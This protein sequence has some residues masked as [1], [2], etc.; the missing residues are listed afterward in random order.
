MTP[1]TIPLPATGH[2]SQPGT[3]H[4]PHCGKRIG[5]D[6]RCPHVDVLLTPAENGG[7]WGLVVWD[8]P[9]EVPDVTRV[10][11]RELSHDQC[12][13]SGIRSNVLNRRMA[14]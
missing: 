2:R 6:A 3:A 13:S 1:T 8:E 12:A 5:M 4:C 10:A 11:L 9:F 14:G 7:E